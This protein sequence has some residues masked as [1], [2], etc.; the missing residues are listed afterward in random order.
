MSASDTGDLQRRRSVKNI[1]VA[2]VLQMKFVLWF[3]L[4]GVV[5]GVFYN[6][7]IRHCADEAVVPLLSLPGVTDAQRSAVLERVENLT[8]Q[9]LTA[10]LLFILIL[11]LSGLL[12]S[13]QTAGP[14]HQL[15]RLFRSVRDGDLSVRCKLRAYD[16]IQDVGDAFNEMMTSLEERSSE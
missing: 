3:T 9:S 12:Y 6:V 10:T 5:L 16:E 1:L 8:S 11:A 2:P 15:K 14:L 7:F 13:H 4:P